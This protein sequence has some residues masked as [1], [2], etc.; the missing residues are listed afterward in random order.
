MGI[1]TKILNFLSEPKSILAFSTDQFTSKLYNQITKDTPIINNIILSP[2]S[3]STALAMTLFGAKSKTAEELKSSLALPDN[4]QD[5]LDS[6]WPFF[7]GVFL[8][9]FGHIVSTLVILQP[10]AL[11][12]HNNTYARYY[13]AP[14]NIITPYPC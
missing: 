11:S 3:L 9:N 13:I 1:K 5:I 2:S 7:Y 14:L 8:V 12:S 10:C 4:D 6:K